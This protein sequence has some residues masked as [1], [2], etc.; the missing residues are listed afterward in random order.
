MIKELT[1]MTPI[2]F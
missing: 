1:A 2:Q